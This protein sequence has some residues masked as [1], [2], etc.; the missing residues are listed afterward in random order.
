[1][2]GNSKRQGGSRA[3]KGGQDASV[4]ACE[5]GVLL[6]LLCP[7]NVHNTCIAADEDFRICAMHASKQG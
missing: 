5:A 3:R 6:L 7:S 4:T 2:Q 1:V